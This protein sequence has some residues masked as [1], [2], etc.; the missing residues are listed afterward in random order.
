M[1]CLEAAAVG[2]EASFVEEGAQKRRVQIAG[3]V[4]TEGEVLQ[5]GRSLVRGFV[6]FQKL[7]R[8]SVDLVGTSNF[9]GQQR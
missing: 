8:E 6:G 5:G 7:L 3:V 1:D 9:M 4:S 2:F